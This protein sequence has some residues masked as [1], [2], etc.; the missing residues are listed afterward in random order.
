MT[1]RDSRLHAFRPDLADARLQGEVTAERFVAGRP[2]RISASVAD[3]RKAPRPDSGLNTQLL[4]GDEVV[5]FEE[6][7]GFAWLQA[8]RDGYVGYV[9][10]GDLAPR[11]AEPTHVVTALR[12]FVYPGPDMKSPRNGQLSIGSQV[13][14]TG[15]AETRGTRYGLL[16]SGEAVVLQHLAPLGTKSDDFVAVAERLIDTPYLWGGFSAFGI[17]C[18]GLVQL[19]MRMTGRKVLRDS[20][21]QEASLGTPVDAGAEFSQLRRGDLVFWKGH[22]AIMTDG[23]NMIHANGHTMTVAREGLRQAID[24]IGYLYGGPTSFRRP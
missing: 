22:V 2:A 3:V 17:D 21:M 13:T 24:R 7:E 9:S 10:S 16:P 1:A 19:S 8:E 5:V 23:E 20:D 15:F 6:A 4:Y 12:S 11:G 18:S 14:V